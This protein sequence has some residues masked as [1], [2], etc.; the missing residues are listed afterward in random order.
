[1]GDP[2]H[3]REVAIVALACL[4]TGAEGVLQRPGPDKPLRRRLEEH[5]AE[6]L[7]GLAYRGSTATL[8]AIGSVQQQVA[9]RQARPPGAQGQKHTRH[10]QRLRVPVAKEVVG[11]LGVKASSCPTNK[12]NSGLG[13]EARGARLERK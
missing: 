7:L 13:P 2:D 9:S 6:A 4:G 12:R 10:H 3:V 11:G 1:M 5:V 8:H